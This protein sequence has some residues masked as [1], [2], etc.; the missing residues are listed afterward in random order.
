MDIHKRTIKTARN[1]SGLELEIC[2][3]AGQDRSRVLS[4]ALYQNAVGAVVVVDVTNLRALTEAQHW[5]REI[6]EKTT[7]PDGRGNKYMM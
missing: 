1:K 4:R 5:K 7:L 2:D 6:E 3:M